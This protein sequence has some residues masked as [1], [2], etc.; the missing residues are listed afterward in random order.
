V[1]IELEAIRWSSVTEHTYQANVRVKLHI[2]AEPGAGKWSDAVSVFDLSDKLLN[3]LSNAES[4]DDGI[5]ALRLVESATDSMFAELM[6]NVDTYETY[7]LQEVHD[8]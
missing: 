1:F 5:G 6:H 3:A 4:K 8:K 7:V 2:V